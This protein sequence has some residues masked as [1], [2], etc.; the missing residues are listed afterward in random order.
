MLGN[1]SYCNPTR[2]HFGEDAMAHLK[3]ELEQ[4]GPSVL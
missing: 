3:Q 4:Y 1:F 2:L